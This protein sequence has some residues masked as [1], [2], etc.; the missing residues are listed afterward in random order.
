MSEAAVSGLDKWLH[1][2]VFCG[3]Q[4]LIH[5]WDTCL[6]RQS[7]DTCVQDQFIW[8]R[9]LRWGCL[10]TWFCYLL[11]AK[12]GDKTT[13]PLWPDPNMANVRIHSKLKITDYFR[14]SKQLSDKCQ[15]NRVT[16]DSCIHTAR[17]NLH[18]TDGEDPLPYCYHYRKQQ[19][20]KRIH[21]I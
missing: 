1:P 18:S 11:I 21:N 15:R 13:A 4:L 8:V 6:W 14:L 9:S 2:T 19:A 17:T 12:P 20:I 16:C 7:P 10:V 3:M 5:A